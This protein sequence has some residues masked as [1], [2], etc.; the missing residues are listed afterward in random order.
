MKRENPDVIGISETWLSNDISNETLGLSDYNVFRADR[1]GGN[2]PHGGVLIG[3]RNKFQAKCVVSDPNFETVIAS[4]QV[5]HT[6]I[7]IVTCYRTPSMIISENNLFV[8]FLRSKLERDDKY[9]MMG[10]FNYPGIQWSN[11][12]ASN[13]FENSFVNFVNE[14]CLHQHV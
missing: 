6:C 13:Q 4:L 8:D 3:V 14:N 9:V 2:D 7:K 1:G 10:D 12:S 11:F 5:N